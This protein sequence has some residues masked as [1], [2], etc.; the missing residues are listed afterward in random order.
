MITGDGTTAE[1][2]PGTVPRGV[3]PPSGAGGRFLS[4]V[5]VQLGFADR[6]T[7]DQALDASRAPGKKLGTTLVE[8][9]AL[10][11]RQL[12]RAVAERYRLDYLDLAEFD[13]DPEAVYVVGDAEMRRYDAVPVAFT[14]DGALVVAMIDPADWLAAEEMAQMTGRRIRRAVAAPSE[15]IELIARVAEA[16]AGEGDTHG[17]D[18]G[19]ATGVPV[20]L[21][22]RPVARPLAGRALGR[23]F[24]LEGSRSDGLASDGPTSPSEAPAEGHA[25]SEAPSDVEERRVIPMSL[26]ARHE[27]PPPDRA[28]DSDSPAGPWQAPSSEV[29]DAPEFGAAPQVESE[30][31]PVS[32][33]Q[34]SEDPP[35]DVLEEATA[36]QVEDEPAHEGDLESEATT[37]EAGPFVAMS[38]SASGSHEPAAQEADNEPLVFEAPLSLV[39]PAEAETDAAD[40]GDAVADGSSGAWPPAQDESATHE[41]AFELPDDSR[42]D[43]KELEQL[44]SELAAARVELGDVQPALARVLDE[45]EGVRGDLATT[46]GRYEG[47]L[48]RTAE[49]E[50]LLAESQAQAGRL[51][52]ELT[53]SK[54]QAQ[55]LREDLTWA[56]GQIENH[57]QREDEALAELRGHI[58]A[59]KG[60][61]PVGPAPAPAKPGADAPTDVS[62]APADG[63]TAPY[64]PES[65]GSLAPVN[66]S[67]APA[68]S[69]R[70]ETPSPSTNGASAPSAEVARSPVSYADAY[71][72]GTVPAIQPDAGSGTS[73]ARGLKRLIA[74]VRRL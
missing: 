37:G 50:R 41:G 40:E 36:D 74:A 56:R 57:G 60:L 48:E 26:P 27:E 66:G 51:E 29:A 53:A 73:K 17:D 44:R 2:D 14:E 38:D 67:L 49:A 59:M 52:A 55:S 7:V 21:T 42:S 8:M 15:V 32:D 6:E 22:L 10:T 24:G 20:R 45:L 25:A 68:S 34:A 4:D 43:A 65:N 47:A 64:A 13:I 16:R 11:E 35:A 33:S 12:G 18:S 62:T 39:P 72:N 23:E 19:A 54:E 46:R 69:S 31:D 61:R 58:D 70:E 3:T 9:G 30:R 63:A 1:I 5:I 28:D 71:S